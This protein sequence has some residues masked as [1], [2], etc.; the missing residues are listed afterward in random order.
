MGTISFNWEWILKGELLE[1]YKIKSIVEK[2]ERI[3]PKTNKLLGN[4]F[5]KVAMGTRTDNHDIVHFLTHATFLTGQK[6]S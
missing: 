2:I 5:T 6:D 3:F 1:R 4:A